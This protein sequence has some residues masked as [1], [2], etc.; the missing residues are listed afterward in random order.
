MRAYLCE[1]CDNFNYMHIIIITA[2]TTYM[3]TSTKLVKFFS[4]PQNSFSFATLLKSFDP[5]L[6]VG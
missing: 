5:S 2:K 6:L 3:Q 1:V 4:Q